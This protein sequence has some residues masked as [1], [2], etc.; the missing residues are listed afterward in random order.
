MGQLS[1]TFLELLL[2]LSRIWSSQN[3]H[4]VVGFVQGFCFFCT[5]ECD[6]SIFYRFAERLCW[7]SFRWW[8]T[9]NIWSEGRLACFICYGWAYQ[10]KA[11]CP[12]TLF[13]LPYFLHH[14]SAKDLSVG[15][16]RVISN[17]VVV[18][19][20]MRHL[21]VGFFLLVIIIWYIKVVEIC[22]A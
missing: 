20:F 21:D 5:M 2:F 22:G 9:W 16:I 19:F 13:L 1:I 12:G 8:L 7:S 18:V 10:S 15:I 11:H 14:V 17:C 6:F 3:Q 4:Q